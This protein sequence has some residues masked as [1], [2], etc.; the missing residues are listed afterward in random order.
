[1]VEIN[2]NVD[3]SEEDASNG[4]NNDNGLFGNS[5]KHNCNQLTEHENDQWIVEHMIEGVS[6]SNA[7]LHLWKFLSCSNQHSVLPWSIITNSSN[8]RGK[9]APPWQKRLLP[10]SFR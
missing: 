2:K 4:T 10:N 3:E 1:L 6:S 9:T 8:R 5:D 7:K